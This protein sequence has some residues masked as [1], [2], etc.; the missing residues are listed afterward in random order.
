MPLGPGCGSYLGSAGGARGSGGGRGRASTSRSSSDPRYIGAPREASGIHRTPARPSRALKKQAAERAEAACC[1]ISS[2]NCKQRGAAERDA[3][4]SGIR[5]SLKPDL[6]PLYA[7]NHLKAGP[8]ALP[9]LP[10]YP[11]VCL[12]DPRVQHIPRIGVA[13]AGARTLKASREGALS[14]SRCRPRA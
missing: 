8:R 12:P 2:S 13:C 6:Q 7:C 4:P 14:T 10:H 3:I 9:V 5:S 11:L 1:R